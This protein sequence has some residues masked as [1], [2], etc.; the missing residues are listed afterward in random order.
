MA[1]VASG[2]DRAYGC[3]VSRLLDGVHGY[4]W[5]LTGSPADADELA[6]ET[7]LR[8][9]TEAHRF[10]ADRGRVSTWVYRIAHNLAL[11]R[12]R[13][14]RGEVTGLDD[15]DRGAVEAA[16]LEGPEHQQQ[17]QEELRQ[18][19]QALA[20]LPLKQRSAL[21]LCRLHGF[22]NAE[23]AAILGVRVRALESLLARARR[24]L[25]QRL[26]KLPT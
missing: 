2:D 9:W 3:L 10:R 19:R 25:R 14:R 7:W 26:E 21:M 11:D 22:S 15:S 4:L 24:G 17:R 1:Q 12:V 20:A 13:A 18:L 6:Q 8:V 23:A 5:R 16:L